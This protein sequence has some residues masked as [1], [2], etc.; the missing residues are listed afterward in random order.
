MQSFFNHLDRLRV[1]VKHANEL[2][3]HF[4][5][6]TKVNGE[7]PRDTKTALGQSQ[8]R[9]GVHEG[10]ISPKMNVIKG[11]FYDGCHAFMHRRAFLFLPRTAV[12][13]QHT[14]CLE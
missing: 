2:R 14:G 8:A 4:F 10:E 9:M 6:M 12:P 3:Y 1:E 5:R 7:K 13:C 11:A